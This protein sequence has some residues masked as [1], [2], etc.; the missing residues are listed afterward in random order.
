MQQPTRCRSLS[1]LLGVIQCFIQYG[2]L[3]ID[4]NSIIAFRAMQLMPGL[5]DSCGQE[6]RIT[7]FEGISYRET[8]D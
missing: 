1:Q 8:Q 3:P 5:S 7:A 2:L 6:I 4:G